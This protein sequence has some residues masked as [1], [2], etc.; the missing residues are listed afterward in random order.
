MSESFK[1]SSNPAFDA[2][3]TI[4]IA[5]LGLDH[6]SETGSFVLH[7]LEQSAF[8][9]LL[10]AIPMPVILLELP[11]PLIQL[12]NPAAKRFLGSDLSVKGRSLF[13]LCHSDDTRVVQRAITKLVA[14]RRHQ[15]I[16]SRL[17][18]P[19]GLKS[20]RIHFQSLRLTGVKYALLLIEDLTHEKEKLNE[21]GKEIQDQNQRLR[22]EILQKN[23]VETELKTK[24]QALEEALWGSIQALARMSEVR[25]PYTAGHQKR[26]TQLAL[27]VA[28]EM[29]LSENRKIIVR[30]AGSVHDIGK[31][32]V[33]AKIL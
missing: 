7:G 6:L 2:T 9:K 8:G 15:T 25:D 19:T 33:P 12:A 11:E 16:E 22:S 1:I 31:V 30:I 4:D 3:E 32:D 20:S 26:V 23:R 5:K 21:K 27:A 17:A 14:T 24:K 28:N 18:A 29:D 10:Y 13:S